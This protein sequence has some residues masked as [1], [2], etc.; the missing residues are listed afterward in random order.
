[1]RRCRDDA[2]FRVALRIHPSNSSSSL[3]MRFQWMSKMGTNGSS[4]C[5]DEEEIMVF[6]D[7]MRYSSVD[8]SGALKL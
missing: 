6:G 4:A 3:I 5:F 1:M 8:T 7:A 2:N